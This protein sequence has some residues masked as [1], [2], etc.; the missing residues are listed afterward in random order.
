M[1]WSTVKDQTMSI[2]QK[3]KDWARWSHCKIGVTSERTQSSK[4]QVQAYV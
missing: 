4:V 1:Q 3:T 2:T